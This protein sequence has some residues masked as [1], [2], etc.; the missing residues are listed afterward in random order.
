MDLIY[1][2]INAEEEK[3][4]VPFKLE[5][6]KPGSA[7]DKFM[8]ILKRYSSNP[9]MPQLEPI[10]FSPQM[11]YPA[12]K[13]TVMLKTLRGNMERII[14]QDRKRIGEMSADELDVP[15]GQKD[16]N[17][18]Q[19]R[20]EKL[21]KRIKEHIEA[22][23]EIK[24]LLPGIVKDYRDRL[25]NFKKE[26]PQA[27]TKALGDRSKDLEWVENPPITRWSEIL[28]P[29]S[30]Q[31]AL[32]Q[33][34][35][36]KGI[37]DPKQLKE[38]GI[39]KKETPGAKF[40]E[41][42]KEMVQVTKWKELGDL[43]KLTKRDIISWMRKLGDATLPSPE[44]AKTA[45][46]DK[47]TE[48]EIAIHA[49]P[50]INALKQRFL[51]K[52]D[53]DFREKDLYMQFFKEHDPEIAKSYAKSWNLSSAEKYIDSVKPLKADATTEE[54]KKWDAVVKLKK[55]LKD[56]VRGP[57]TEKQRAERARD[58]EELDKE[59]AKLKEV[60]EKEKK[61][62]GEKDVA[63]PSPVT[64]KELEKS[65]EKIKELTDKW[66]GLVK[67]W[68]EWRPMEYQE[69]LEFFD[70][71][72][73][74]KDYK[75]IPPAK[76]PV[77]S[78]AH[79]I[80]SALKDYKTMHSMY[81]GVLW[82]RNKIEEKP[83]EERHKQFVTKQAEVVE[84]E[85]KDDV[86]LGG[87][88]KKANGLKADA[89]EEIGAFGS[90]DMYSKTGYKKA[91]VALKAT[92]KF[93]T[94][95]EEYLKKL[96]G[97]MT[98]EQVQRLMKEHAGLPGYKEQ[99]K[100][101]KYSPT[102]F[103]KHEPV[104]A[105]IRKVAEELG[106][107]ALVKDF[108]KAFPYD[109]Y[110]EKI[111]VECTEKPIFDH[112]MDEL[113]MLYDFFKEEFIDPRK[114][115]VEKSTAMK[116]T[117]QKFLEDKMKVV[118][119]AALKVWKKHNEKAKEETPM[120]KEEGKGTLKSHPFLSDLLD[121]F[122]KA[123]RIPAMVDL[124]K[125]YITK[126]ITE[127]E[128]YKFQKITEKWMLSD[129]PSSKFEADIRAV[130]DDLEGG[131]GGGA[132]KGRPK[133]PK[134]PPAQGMAEVMK[135]RSLKY[136]LKFLD[137]E[138][139]PKEL[140]KITVEDFLEG[141]NSSYNFNTLDKASVIRGIV[142]V[143]RSIW[144]NMKILKVVAPGYSYSKAD[145]YTPSGMTPVK[146]VG[147]H[148]PTVPEHEKLQKLW[149]T[150]KKEKKTD[151]PFEDWREEY[152]DKKDWEDEVKEKKTSLS[153]E[154]WRKE[155]KGKAK[156]AGR[157]GPSV[158]HHAPGQKDIGE[159]TPMHMKTLVEVGPWRA[160]GKGYDLTL[161]GTPEK[162]LDQ[163][164]ALYNHVTDLR[165]EIERV[166]DSTIEEEY[167]MGLIESIDQLH[168]ELKKGPHAPLKTSDVL[169]DYP[170]QMSANVASK[171]IGVELPDNEFD[172]VMS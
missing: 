149:E 23:K 150:E 34:E 94:A 51:K 128:K 153:F 31:E 27:Y 16:V 144:F 139:T 76:Y 13:I 17:L 135:H 6:V 168:K 127:E 63:K 7:T 81:H 129:E 21:T 111:K 14:D 134:V 44:F 98:E 97:S 108:E 25:E 158:P 117:P 164:M 126:A 156:E 140:V 165:K 10:V 60:I 18:G 55:D 104:Q 146:D 41:K 167:P 4:E 52:W 161:S 42:A 1:N 102:R 155:Q 112:A 32:R 64:P 72:K 50:R 53:P 33:E 114:K 79:I 80:A 137:G 5:P 84:A 65:H 89:V 35:L 29:V 36:E 48:S 3:K 9:K 166:T 95:A 54:E 86:S 105:S 87:Q 163:A 75:G 96:T 100:K 118:M 151:L 2:R 47:D 56:I 148:T 22:M 83:L 57:L 138:M 40:M 123:E 82:A 28:M 43:M 49:D 159:K 37:L 130:E 172:A 69:F 154:D 115:V 132:S 113:D 93:I 24:G 8:D 116:V 91:D 61:E 122:I 107:S 124:D 88:Y 141:L 106:R 68:R 62:K 152:S 38:R 19:I 15:R 142:N 45:A 136:L 160:R 30:E 74:D 170:T 59:V 147:K 101:E 12:G 110:K 67:F 119:E 73:E 171:F 92:V 103:V 26:N 157:Y 143:L 20:K 46:G 77:T 70:V 39:L 131:G 120:F 121:K 169:Y 162:Q 66:E 109:E 71:Y 85:D 11:W 78:L 145:P 133:A 90:Q 99:E 125:V 58:Q